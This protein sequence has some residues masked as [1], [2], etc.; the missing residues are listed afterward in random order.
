MVMAASASPAH[1]ERF[2]FAVGWDV[3]SAGDTCTSVCQSGR[4]G[5]DA[6][7]LNEPGAVTIV[8]SE[9]FV[10]DGGNHRV[11]VFDTGSGAFVRA[12][13]GD[14]GGPGVHTCTSSCQAGT[15][16]SG[17]GQLGG[18]GRTAV[19]AGELFVPE[20]FDSQVSV[21][22]AA[23]GAY[24]RAFGAFGS[25]A[26]QLLGPV[27]VAVAGD[28]VFVAES[29]NQRISVFDATTGAFKRAFGSDVAPNGDDL[30]NTGTTCKMGV[31]GTGAGQFRFP[32]G[33]AIAGN[34][35]FVADSNNNRI[36]EFDTAGTFVRAFGKDVGGAGVNVCTSSCERPA[37]G[38]AA[39]S[40]G[41]PAS[42]R[43]D[44]GEL[45]VSERSNNRV[46]VFNAT[47][48][49]FVRALGKDVGG[50]GVNV[51]SSSCN[52][53]RSGDGSAGEITPEGTAIADGRLFVAEDENHRLSVLDP[54]SGAFVRAHGKGVQPGGAGL[55]EIC[56]F[57]CHAGRAG[58]GAGH[59]MTPGATA[60]AGGELFVG[61]LGNARI[62]VF[63][64][65]SGA[66][67]RAFG[68]NVGGG[69][70]HTCT[71]SCQAGDPSAYPGQIQGV[72]GLAANGGR[73]FISE[74]HRM[75]VLDASSG[76]FTHASGKDVG[77]SGINTCTSGCATGVQGTGAGHL[78]NPRGVGA[79]GDEVFVSESYNHRVSVFDAATGAFKRAFG[80]DVG[81]DGINTCKDSCAQGTRDF[82]TNAPGLN[83]PEGLAVAGDKVFVVDGSNRRVAV[84]DV[85]GTF[86][87]G[88][89]S[90]GSG[91]G[92]LLAPEGVAVAGNEVFVAE[93]E[94]HRV[95]VFNWQ[96][97][98]F[99]RAFGKNVGGADVNTCT[100]TCQQGIAGDGAGEFDDPQDVR[101]AGN[102]V[103][104]ADANNNRIQVFTSSPDATAP[105]T[106]ITDGPSGSTNDATPSFTF[107]SSEPGSLFECRIDSGSFKSCSSPHI[108]EALSD[109]AHTFAVR[110][111]DA[112]WN[113]DATADTRA[114]TVDT[115]VAPPDPEPSPTPTPT[116]TPEAPPAPAPPP[117]P[118]P[119]A[120]TPPL[121]L[122]G[123][124][125]S[126]TRWYRS[127][128]NRRGRRVGTA[129]RYTLNRAA[130]V[131]LTFTRQTPGR[132]SGR[133]CVKPTRRL[134]RA[135]RCTLSVLAGTLRRS[136]P[137][138]S[139]SLRFTGR[140]SSRRLLPGGTYTVTIRARDAS[141]ESAP[142]RLRFRILG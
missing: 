66:F 93:S 37:G 78:D 68:A 64:A 43:V 94:N 76:A 32:L 97:G 138:G 2:A 73:L 70:I 132:R 31:L 21:F 124:R 71:T 9:A 122:T 47:T 35:V 53:G 39:G 28:E 141:G 135:R 95:S 90:M 133:R 5:D 44:S 80:K 142:A 123:V 14:V 79:S 114:F 72:A 86:I 88:F 7:H 19:R 25:G 24:V 106:T 60:V 45:F 52:A 10:S 108:T 125:Q 131:T 4:P 110:A 65:A 87:R 98:E 67:R 20:V 11:S 105:D 57:V 49:A 113:T 18:A 85:S 101:V 111:I 121:R 48:G 15:D 69:G 27:A 112:V 16:G 1:A 96:T 6:G 3:V 17:T 120:T 129:F 92:E 34:Q 116:P 13:G 118:P 130:T 41:S 42:V 23:S 8:G 99:L 26:G 104:V 107:A 140:L 89:G 127:G 77:G 126:N 55:L 100:N 103:Y 134:L 82:G 102:G 117:P 109:G 50:A 12:F 137:L 136:S 83:Y 119:A 38:S 54:T 33:L 29:T 91:A 75:P 62:S 58:S 30:C 115:T 63:D 56:R 22:N 128:R 46:S 61:E 40:L 84:F 74:V 139:T 59:L 51:C 36:S 81:G